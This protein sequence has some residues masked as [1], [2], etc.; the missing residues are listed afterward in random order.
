MVK[1]TVKNVKIPKLWGGGPPLGSFSHKSRF[2]DHDPKSE[3]TNRGRGGSLKKK[4]TLQN[5]QHCKDK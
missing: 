2:S 1:Q 5:Q 4:D 3:I